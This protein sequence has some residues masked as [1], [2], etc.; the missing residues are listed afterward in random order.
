[1][2]D[3]AD[4]VVALLVLPDDL[5]V[6]GIGQEG[7]ER[8]LD[9]EGRLDDIGDIARVLLLIEIRQV[10]AGRVLMLRQ[11][12]IRAVGNAQSSPQPNG[13]RNSKSVVALE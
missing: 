13:N 4:V 10:F 6:V 9:A 8:A 2:Q 5:F 12:I 7:Q 11:V 3:G 1:M